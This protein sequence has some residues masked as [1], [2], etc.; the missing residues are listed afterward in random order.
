M[1][2]P[3]LK[4]PELRDRGKRV[5][6]SKKMDVGKTATYAQKCLDGTAAQGRE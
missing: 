1:V 3:N 6:K 5:G 4:T 2:Y